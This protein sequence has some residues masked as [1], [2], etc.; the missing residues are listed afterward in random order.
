MEPST[1]LPR[2]DTQLTQWSDQLVREVRLSEEEAFGVASAAASEL[3]A[4]SDSEQKLLQAADPIS[5]QA[6]L[7][8]LIAFQAFMD[9][10][11]T[12]RSN[13]EVT[14]AQVAVQLYIGFVY[15]GDSCF[16]PL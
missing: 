2:L 9:W 5:P 1:W 12:V 4:R 3:A 13:P 10:A 6:R 15:L 8:E 7:D 16:R 11:S 14:R